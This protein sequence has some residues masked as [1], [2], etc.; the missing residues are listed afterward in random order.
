[1]SLDPRPPVEDP[2]PDPSTTPGPGEFSEE[3][4]LADPEFAEPRIAGGV[5]C[6]GG[7]I[8]GEYVS[9]RTLVRAPAIDA[10]KSRLR[11]EGA[12]VIEF[13]N[14]LMPPHYPS[15][16]QAKLLLREGVQ[17]PIVRS[18]T[19]ISIV[20][21]FGA[22]I[23]DVPVPDLRSAIKED[24]SGTSLAHLTQGLFEAHARDE[25]GHRDQGGHKQMW[26]AARDL[27]FD[28]PKVPGDVLAGL[29]QGRGR[30][31]RPPLFPTLPEKVEGLIA[32]M[33]NVMVIEIFADD[34]FSWGEALLGDPELSSQP[35]AASSMVSH[36]R[37][38]EAPHVEYLR[39]VSYTH[40]TLPT[41]REV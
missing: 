21:G 22:M 15:L 30:N 33:S 12:G 14:E 34:V 36:I 6:H 9:P 27:A 19:T 28:N 41:N 16:E 35:E 32:S 7:F 3:Q 17:K 11:S 8:N 20:E 18:L 39:T 5:R 4:I 24:I 2:T 26:E 10:W 38:D 13:S 23:R 25:A 37:A 31:R 29:M 1:M 40:L